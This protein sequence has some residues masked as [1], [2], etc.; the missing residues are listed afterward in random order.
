MANELDTNQ[1][2]ILESVKAAIK[3]LMSAGTDI[4]PYSVAREAEIDPVDVFNSKPAMDELIKARGDAATY[5]I[6]AE[7]ALQYQEISQELEKAVGINQE[8]YDRGSELAERV[9]ELEA[10]VAELETEAEQLA[11]QLQN[12]WS[13]GYQK[14]L[15][16]AKE[17]QVM[18]TGEVATEVI[19][20]PRVVAGPNE[21]VVST[22]EELPIVGEPLIET[23]E[24]EYR[25]IE[26]EDESAPEVKM[27]APV[28]AASAQE[29]SGQPADIAGYNDRVFNA[30]K[31]GP[32]GPKPSDLYS[33]LSWKQIETTY[34]YSTVQGRAG[35]NLYFEP[36]PS[37]DSPEPPAPEPAPAPVPAPAPAPVPAPAP[38]PAPEPERRQRKMA[39][40]SFDPPEE[41]IV[42]AGGRIEGLADTF[43][44]SLSQDPFTQ[45]LTD[46]PS[47][48]SMLGVGQTL[49]QSERSP[50]ERPPSR[51]DTVDLSKVDEKKNAE[52]ETFSALTALPL[53]EPGD[54]LDL[55]KLDIF[56]GLEDIEELSNIEVI[57]D[58]I[59]P[60]EPDKQ[61]T[62]TNNASAIN[63]DLKDLIK[64]RIKQAHDNQGEPQSEPLAE[65][66]GEQAQTQSTGQP[67]T[68]PA[69]ISAEAIRQG[70]RSKF[71]GGK[72]APSP[73]PAVAPTTATSGTAPGAPGAT[74]GSTQGTTQGSIPGSTPG[75]ATAGASTQSA[76]IPSE[77]AAAPGTGTGTGTAAP[78][79][80]PPEIR[81]N[82]MILGV[83][84]EDLTVK[85]VI[86]AW[87]AQITAPGVHPDQGGDHET[88]LY[89][90]IAKETLVK[91]VE[92]QAPKLGKK[93]G[94]QGAV[95]QNPDKGTDKK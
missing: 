23:H 32:A 78:R 13:V 15:A 21:S 57:E 63:G 68:D 17:K 16:D 93:F 91:Y 43:V 28:G 90:N 35:A 6:D 39:N 45:S 36:L 75:A 76:G 61:S 24:T 5:N 89:L 31:E 20:P 40:I 54:E 52:V 82:C 56:E 46:A 58:V 95:R 81:K 83:R 74:Q 12:A 14:G 79:A 7:L 51:S 72:S 41:P 73:G 84:P 2:A 8:L 62:S 80:V 29:Q 34:Q 30:V 38:A 19:P 44:E 1:E 18:T 87:K 27:P 25:H 42:G 69:S 94:T 92:S 64:N 49:S 53:S 77:P 11:M 86:D 3:T 66:P 22:G 33:A 67:A 60:D 37:G 50:F 55:D 9:V 48:N 65:T 88:A 26:D 59:L 47:L 10:K 4:N 85:N 71:V 70:V